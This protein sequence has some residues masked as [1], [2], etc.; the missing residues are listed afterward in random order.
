MNS[1][2]PSRLERLIWWGTLVIII[3]LP[4]HV[5]AYSLLHQHLPA[6]S[7]PFRDW[8]EALTLLLNL[9]ALATL[10]WGRSLSALRR[11]ADLWLIAAFIAL[12]AGFMA[13]TPDTGAALLAVKVNLVFLLLYAAASL[14]RGLSARRQSVLVLAVLIPAGL[15]GLFG[16]LQFFLPNDVLVHFGFGYGP[17][18]IHP[19]E[20]IAGSTI[21]RI[22]SFM[23]GPNQYGSY[24]ALPLILAA[25]VA[26]TKRAAWQRVAAAVLAIILLVNLYGTQ[27][28]GS[29]IGVL[30]GLMALAWLLLHGCQRWVLAGLAAAVLVVLAIALPHLTRS[31]LAFQ[32]R[33]NAPEAV[34]TARS[35]DVQHY[36]RLKA[37]LA[38]VAHHPLGEGLTA[39][40]RASD[41][42]GQSFYTENFYLQIADQVGIEGL[43]LFLAVIAVVGW[44]LWNLESPLAPPLFAA[45]VG[46]SVMNLFSHTWSDGATA[47][48]WWGAAGLALGKG[49][50]E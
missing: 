22:Q 39:A 48:L 25:W 1:A 44:T 4:F 20:T 8:K 28:R 37:G 11:R 18:Q 27:S 16:L 38:K 49:G 24:L 31:P 13:A 17:D 45:L 26:A 32:L 34:N 50:R 40:G 23:F 10:V 6:I 47:L 2:W 30:A 29:W 35:S 36:L 5:L 19:F 12:N 3:G 21:L 15:A 33:H 46:L 42:A 41:L 43:G 7:G 9:V 14:G